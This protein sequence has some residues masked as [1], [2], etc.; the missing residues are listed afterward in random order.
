MEIVISI[1]IYARISKT[2]NGTGGKVSIAELIAYQIGWGKCLIRWYEAGIQGKVPE[3][4]G[5]GFLTWDYIAIARYFYQ[6]YIHDSADQQMKVFHQTV[7][8]IFEIVHIEHQ[9]G[10]LDRMGVWQW[11]TLSSG[12]K[13][14][15]GKWIQVNTVSPYKRAA[16]LIKK[17]KCTESLKY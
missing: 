14:S 13:W 16:Q 8:R 3:M 4:P 1:P 6:K 11:C 15:L 2:I 9:M 5:E 12:K 10:N 17:A 7:S